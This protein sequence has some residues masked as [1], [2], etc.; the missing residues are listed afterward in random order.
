ML[1]LEQ[2]NA[3]NNANLMTK[4]QTLPLLRI[5]QNTSKEIFGAGMT[6]YDPS[7]ISLYGCILVKGPIRNL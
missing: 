4:M 3:N 6:R 5:K 1:I 7:L 2:V